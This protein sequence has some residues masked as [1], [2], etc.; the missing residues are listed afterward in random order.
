MELFYELPLSKPMPKATLGM[1]DFP[2]IHILNRDLG[3]ILDLGNGNAFIAGGAARLWYEN[4]DVGTHDVDVYFFSEKDWIRCHDRFDADIKNKQTFVSTNASTFTV[5]NKYK[6]Q[7]IKTQFSKDPYEIINNFDI[8]VCKIATDGY[9]WY[10]GENFAQD[11]KNRVL[12]FD[13]V[14]SKFLKRYIKYQIY[15]FEP[16]Q[17]LEELANLCSEDAIWDFSKIDDTEDYNAN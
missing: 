9:K 3:N 14:T 1:T 4:R 2:A 15:G 11:L 16:I 5:D 12:R 13:K 7:L 17:T 10:L 8:S 6:I